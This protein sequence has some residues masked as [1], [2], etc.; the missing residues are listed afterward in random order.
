MT[1]TVVARARS[2]IMA[3]RYEL[4]PYFARSRHGIL[5]IASR[6]VALAAKY[7]FVLNTPGLLLF[8]P[9]RNHASHCGSLGSEAAARLDPL[10]R[11]VSLFLLRAEI[12][13]L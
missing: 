10:L 5:V 12:K 2:P 11:I 8:V 6:D 1:L 4:L 7:A 13:Y 9:R 3:L